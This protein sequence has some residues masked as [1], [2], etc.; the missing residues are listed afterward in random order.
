MA[1]LAAR[2]R[3]AAN[4]CARVNA[5][6]ALLCERA[7]DAAMVLDRANRRH[8]SYV[9]PQCNHSLEG[10]VPAPVPM[11]RWIKGIPPSHVDCAWLRVEYPGG[12]IRVVLGSL[13]THDSNAKR[14]LE[15]CEAADWR[16]E[17]V[18]DSVHEDSGHIRHW[19]PY[20]IPSKNW[21]TTD[22]EENHTCPLCDAQPYQKH[23]PACPRHP[24]D[25]MR[26]RGEGEK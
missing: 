7:L 6:V 18:L 9:C 19:M 5:D 21:P 11:A 17:S 16:G 10:T 15:W 20:L 12:Y 1:D 26:V 4:R 14:P 22:S 25:P 24:S 3:S 2:L 23:A 8:V 13:A